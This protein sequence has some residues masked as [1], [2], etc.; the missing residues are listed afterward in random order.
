VTEH[1]E[2]IDADDAAHDEVEESD[3]DRP[4]PA[5]APEADAFEQHQPAGTS[6]GHRPS[7]LPPDAS[8]ADAL[9]QA[10]DVDSDDGYDR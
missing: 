5:D 3:D 1:P 7:H 10:Q 8:E 6:P 2:E 9:E 4:L